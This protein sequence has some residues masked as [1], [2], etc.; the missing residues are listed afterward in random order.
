MD[1]MAIALR[2]VHS[3]FCVGRRS[4]DELGLLD[5]QG[6]GLARRGGV[7]HRVA[8][9]QG[10][11]HQRPTLICALCAESAMAALSS[12]NRAESEPLRT[13]VVAGVLGDP[14]PVRLLGWVALVLERGQMLTKGQVRPGHQ[15]R[16]GV[17]V[18]LGEAGPVGEHSRCD[19]V[20]REVHRA[21]VLVQPGP[22]IFVEADAPWCGR[23]VLHG[24]TKCSQTGQSVT[25]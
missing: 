15:T 25:V 7:D 8:E 11:V 22:Q 12:A 3:L 18:L 14:A 16:G 17:T 13:G 19:E 5:R 23:H 2:I 9:D 21:R 6:L 20:G 24:N 1:G 4:G 10:V